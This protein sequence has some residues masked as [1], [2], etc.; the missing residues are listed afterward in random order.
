MA[1][2]PTI[3]LIKNKW[4]PNKD[5]NPYSKCPGGNEQR[6]QVDDWHVNIREVTLTYD[7]KQNKMIYNGHTLPCTHADGFCQPTSITPYAIVW[8][9]EDL[10]LMF[11]IHRFIGRMTKLC[12]RY[13]IETSQ[14]FNAT[15]ATESHNT[16]HPFYTTPKMPNDQTR[17][18][19][20]EVF[21]DRHSFCKR[22]TLM[23]TTQ[24]ENI[25]F[26]S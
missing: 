20:F 4:I 25:F 10:C 13:W 19:R 23:L 8:F 6:I 16:S 17:L 21:P 24:Y 22:P 18:A 5:E 12:D 15:I 26:D 3:V 2:I 7:D 1:A 9:P 11:K 14:F